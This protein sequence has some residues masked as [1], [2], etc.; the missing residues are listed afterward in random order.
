[1]VKFNIS[2]TILDNSLLYYMTLAN[3]EDEYVMLIKSKYNEVYN[4]GVK[5]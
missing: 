5:W 1:M 2:K 3:E 4:A